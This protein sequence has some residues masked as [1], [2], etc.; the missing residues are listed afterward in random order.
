MD[1]YTPPLLDRGLKGM[2]GKGQR[3]PEV[4]R[5]MIE[6][7]AVYFAATGGAGALLSMTMTASAVIAYA[8]LG[9]EAIRRITVVDF[10][11]MV[12]NDCYGN[13]LYRQGRAHYETA[14]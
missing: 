7:K 10:P 9:P 4:V 2:I 11:A 6:N 14:D 12:V 5:S 1:P 13:D 8:D 3:G